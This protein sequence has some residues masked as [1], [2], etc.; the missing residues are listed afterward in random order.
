MYVGKVVE[1]GIVD[2]I[3]YNLKYLYIWG[4]IVFMLSLD[5]LEEELYVIFGMFLDLLK[6]LKGDVFVLCNL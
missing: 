5:G 1:I 6:L 4:L 2:E 3:F